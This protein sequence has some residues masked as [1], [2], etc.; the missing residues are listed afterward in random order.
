MRPGVLASLLM[1]SCTFGAAARVSATLRDGQVQYG[2]DLEGSIGVTRLDE[3][4]A[5]T[6]EVSTLRDASGF[7]FLAFVGLGWFEHRPVFT[8]GWDIVKLRPGQIGVSGGIHGS[9]DDECTRIMFGIGPSG[10]LATT[11]ADPR[12][13]S[14]G[15]NPHLK[16]IYHSLNV[17]GGF[18]NCRDHPEVGLAYA[19]GHTDLHFAPGP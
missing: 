18:A 11:H 7:A 17:I 4:G 8:W 5:S 2:G 16:R 14:W 19:V 15:P 1:C 12:P 9:T 13:D 10:V 6:L 3:T